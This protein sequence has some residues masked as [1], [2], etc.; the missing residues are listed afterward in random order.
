MFRTLIYPSA[1][2]CGW[3]LSG[4]RFAGWSL[5]RTPP[6]ISRNRSSNTQRIENKTTDVVIQQHNRKLLTMDILMSETC[7]AHKKWN[8]IASDIKLVFHS[9]T[10]TMMHGPINIRLYCIFVKTVELIYGFWRNLIWMLCRWIHVISSFKESVSIFETHCVAWCMDGI[11]TVNTRQ[12]SD[13][14]WILFPCQQ[15]TI[16]A[17]PFCSSLNWYARFTGKA[18]GIRRNLVRVV[19]SVAMC[20]AHNYELIHRLNCIFGETVCG[21]N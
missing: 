8:K 7:W 1:A 3:F 13:S 12:S 4:A 5:K 2:T 16:L 6:N 11:W 17:K 20:L 19:S 14:Y 9:S 21:S 10:A 15:L 18:G